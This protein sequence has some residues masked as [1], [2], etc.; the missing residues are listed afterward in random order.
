MAGA[1]M[2]FIGI[3]HDSRHFIFAIRQL[4]RYRFGFHGA[5]KFWG[6]FRA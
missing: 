5:G 6:D 1:G 4:G 3:S 2:R